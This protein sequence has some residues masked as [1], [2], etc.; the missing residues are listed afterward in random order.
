MVLQSCLAKQRQSRITY[1][2]KQ[3]YKIGQFESDK[4]CQLR[5]NNVK[6]ALNKKVKINM[7]KML[8]F[9]LFLYSAE[10]WTVRMAD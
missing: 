1:K 7:F 2:T 9:S 6:T 8:V 4:C 3:K 5:V 10:I